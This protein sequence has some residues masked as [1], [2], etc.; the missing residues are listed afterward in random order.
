LGFWF[1]PSIKG[2]WFVDGQAY[3]VLINA[4]KQQRLFP[5]HIRFLARGVHELHCIDDPKDPIPLIVDVSEPER[6]RGR[7]LK[8]HVTPVEKAISL[9]EFDDAVRQFIKALQLAGVALPTD[10]A[11]V[12][13]LFKKK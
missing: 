10:A 6:G 11:D 8:A 7:V 1:K 3:A 13:T 12:L 2:V 9:D 4:R 5:E